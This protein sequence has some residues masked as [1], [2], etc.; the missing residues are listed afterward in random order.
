MRFR[1]IR[2]TEHG[3][4]TH[5]VS[6]SDDEILL[7]FSE[8]LNPF[9]PVISWNPDD[10]SIS[11][12]PDNRYVTLKEHIARIEGRRP[13][14]ICVGN[15]SVELMR[16]FCQAAL[17]PGDRV[18]VPSHTF[19]EYA[20]SVEC[21]GGVPVHPQD[22]TVAEFFCNPNNPTGTLIPKP[23]VLTRIRAHEDAGSLLFIDE[24]FIDLADPAESVA[25]VCSEHAFV[26]RSLT[27]AFSVPGIRFGWGVG[28]PDLVAA[29]EAIRPPWSVNAYAEDY[30]HAA[31]NN[32]CQLVS[33]RERIAEERSFLTDSLTARGI[34][35]C[36]SAV[37]FI[38]F[39]SPVSG[40]DLKDRLLSQGILIRDCASFGLPEYVRIAVRTRDENRMLLEALDI[41]LP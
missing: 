19:G 39:R 14:E 12:Y 38:L 10:I 13:D 32:T 36:P 34:S 33:S 1:R 40:S 7:D 30:A 5:L 37:N 15:G 18:S 4:K 24:A 23:D 8:N 22:G 35:V 26:L 6:G 9:P 17:R 31:L 16:S 21:A 25:G 29:I 3:G 11:S 2:K 20:V 27:K 28:C 41:C